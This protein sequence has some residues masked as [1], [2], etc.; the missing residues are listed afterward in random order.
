MKKSVLILLLIIVA[1][2]IIIFMLGVGKGNGTTQEEVTIWKTENEEARATIKALKSQKRIEDLLSSEKVKYLEGEIEFFKNK[3]PLVV[4]STKFI[5]DTLV[6]EIKGDTVYVPITTNRYQKFNYNDEWAEISG[7]IDLMLNSLTMKYSVKDSVD[8]VYTEEKG[9]YQVDLVS[10]NPHSHYVGVSS[11]KIE[12][13]NK[14][15]LRPGIFTGLSNQGFVYGAGF[16]L[17]K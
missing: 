16:V 12:K 1:L 6:I 14:I 17:T 11:V 3:A 4:T 13:K 7:D 2:I 9:Q 5:T 10:Y 8:M 15:K